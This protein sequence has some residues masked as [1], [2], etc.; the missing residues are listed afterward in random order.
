MVARAEYVPCAAFCSGVHCVRSLAFTLAPSLI[1]IVTVSRN[2]QPAA[3]LASVVMSKAC[4]AVCVK[5]GV[6]RA[7]SSCK[8]QAASEEETCRGCMEGYAGLKVLLEN[9][10]L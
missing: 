6:V 8:A 5:L 2:P 10:C 9:R 1:S 3:T 4:A 7:A